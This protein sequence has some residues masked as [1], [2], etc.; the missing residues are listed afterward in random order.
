[1]VGAQGREKKGADK[2][3][4]GIIS[5]VDKPGDYKRALVSVKGGKNIKREM[6]ATLKGDMAREG[7][8]TGILVTLEEPTGPMKQ[9]AADAG[10]WNSDLHPTRSYPCIQILTVKDILAGSAPDLPSWGLD[11]FKKAKRSK[12]A[13]PKQLALEED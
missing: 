2:G 7:A 8:L 13:T 5:F 9:E 6:I 11:V 12:Q 4:D 3:I 10:R 1:M